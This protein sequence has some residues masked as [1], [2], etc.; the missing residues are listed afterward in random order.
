ME[1][2]KKFLKRKDIELSLRRYSITVARENSTSGGALSAQPMATA[3]AA[4]LM[5]EAYPP[6]STRK[7]RDS[8]CPTVLMMAGAQD[9]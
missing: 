1:P 9:K 2:I 3:I 8:C 7:D 5:A 6:T 4:P